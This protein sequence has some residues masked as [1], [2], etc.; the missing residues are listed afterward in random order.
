MSDAATKSP[1]PFPAK[2]AV[3]ARGGQVSWL[4]AASLAFPGNPPVALLSGQT[5]SR[6]GLSQWRGRAGFAPASE[7]PHPQLV[8]FY[9]AL[10]VPLIS[11]VRKQHGE[12]PGSTTSPLSVLCFRRS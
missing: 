5:E 3:W 8:S 4:E 9:V 10:I 11:L 7:M 12:T 6:S 1:G 2:G